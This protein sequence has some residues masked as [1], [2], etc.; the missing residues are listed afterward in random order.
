MAK[1]HEINTYSSTNA[2]IALCHAPPNFEI[3]NA[4]V[5]LMPDT[6]IQAITGSCMKARPKGP[7]KGANLKKYGRRKGQK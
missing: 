4:L 1:N 3:Q 5:P 7:R 6:P 2:I